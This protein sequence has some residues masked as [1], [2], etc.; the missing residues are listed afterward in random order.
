MPPATK[1]A[2]KGLSEVETKLLCSLPGIESSVIEVIKTLANLASE[3]ADR[4]DRLN[5]RINDLSRQVSGLTQEVVSLKEAAIAKASVLPNVQASQ[6]SQRTKRRSTKSSINRTRST[7][8]G[9]AAACTASTGEPRSVGDTGSDP[10]P[11]ASSEED[12]NSEIIG[13]EGPYSR[14]AKHRSKPVLEVLDDDSWQLVSGEP[15]RSRRAVLY[16]G[17][18]SSSCTE[19]G[20]KSFTQ[21]RAVA[22]GGTATVH[23]CSLH[24]TEAGRV[25]AHLTVD[26]KDLT[27]VTTENF[28]PRPLYARPWRFK[29]RTEQ[30][31]K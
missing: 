3:S 22:A 13:I 1:A 12:S 6:Q 10:E 16:V 18:L 20:L 5:K 29:E 4:E 9:Q 26:A 23:T 2:L 28:W 8:T 11:E 17:N 24:T 27:L 14:R 7:R 31:S 30:Q 15:P 19:E 21:Q 25:S